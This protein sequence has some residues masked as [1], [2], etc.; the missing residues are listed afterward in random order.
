MPDLLDLLVPPPSVTPLAPAAPGPSLPGSVG[1]AQLSPDVLSYIQT[2]GNRSVGRERWV[3]TEAS[4]VYNGLRR[5]HS[6][7]TSDVQGYFL[8]PDGVTRD[9]NITIQAALVGGVPS[10]SLVEFIMP[11]GQSA[12][13]T[14]VAH[15]YAHP[16]TN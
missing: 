4:P 8:L 3:Y 1:L 10:T 5:A 12:T 7:G 14:F 15:A 13:G 6:F 9:P 11:P 2:M 16:D